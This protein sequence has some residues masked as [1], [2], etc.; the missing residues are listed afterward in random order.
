MCAPDLPDT[1]L[2]RHYSRAYLKSMCLCVFGSPTDV[3]KKEIMKE[4]KKVSDAIHSTEY[5]VLV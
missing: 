4:I 5:T 2:H 1:Q 3:R